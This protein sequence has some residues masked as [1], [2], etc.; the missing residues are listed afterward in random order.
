MHWLCLNTMGQ[1]ARSTPPAAVFILA[2]MATSQHADAIPLRCLM[3]LCSHYQQALGCKDQIGSDFTVF[4]EKRIHPF[5][6]YLLAKQS[7]LQ[8]SRVPLKLN[9]SRDGE[10]MPGRTHYCSRKK[11]CTFLF[12]FQKAILAHGGW[13]AK[14]QERLST[15][16]TATSGSPLGDVS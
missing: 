3:C 2:V 12:L 10:R 15:R 6:C 7:L 16:W 8:C 5:D 9:Y 14:A 13:P 4:K 1:D 11:D